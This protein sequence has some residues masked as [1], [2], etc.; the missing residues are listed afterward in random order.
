[1]AFPDEKGWFVGPSATWSVT[2]NMDIMLAGQHFGGRAGSPLDH[3]GHRI[4][5]S[6]KR[7]F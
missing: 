6:A 7:S 2:S 1:M 4:I 3:A 5:L